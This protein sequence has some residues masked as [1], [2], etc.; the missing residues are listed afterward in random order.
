[1]LPA[2]ETAL[3]TEQVGEGPFSTC[4]LPVVP[5]ECR[6]CAHVQSGCETPGIP[7]GKPVTRKTLGMA[8][9][10]GVRRGAEGKGVPWVG[11]LRAMAS[12]AVRSVT[13]CG[14]RDARVFGCNGCACV[15]SGFV[16]GQCYCAACGG[17][18]CAGNMTLY[19]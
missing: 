10:P 6:R 14:Q 12:A 13:E 16:A 4:G 18:G 15:C 19:H 11:D 5:D 8:I 7:Q 1:M 3:Q 9:A 17:S 2:A